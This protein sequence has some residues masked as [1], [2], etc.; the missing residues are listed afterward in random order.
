MEAVD[1][2]NSGRVSRI[3]S[4][5]CDGPG[6][7]S[8]RSTRN[9]RALPR[10][11]TGRLCDSL[12][13][14]APDGVCL[15]RGLPA[16]ARWSL[17]PPFHPCRPAPCG[18]ARRSGFCGTFLSRR[19]PAEFR[20]SRRGRPARWSP[21]FPPAAA[22][23][24]SSAGDRRPELRLSKNLKYPPSGSTRQ[25]TTS[26][27]KSHTGSAARPCGLQPPGP[28]TISC[29]TRCRCHAR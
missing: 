24:R 27:R 7:L 29:G 1:N 20:A 18:A 19:L 12:F 25:D 21:D 3:L 6:H 16:S 14:L 5:V 8:G 4:S 9:R 15:A 11:E 17:T 23:S 28:A 10:V 2:R 22:L 26:G 13:D